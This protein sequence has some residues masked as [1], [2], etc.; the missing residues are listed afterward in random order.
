MG[1]RQA[2]PICVP[3]FLFVEKTLACSTFPVFQRADSNS[4]YLGDEEMAERSHS[5]TMGQ[6]PGSSSGGHSI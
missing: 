5:A 6:G 3:V 4:C 1:P 2:G